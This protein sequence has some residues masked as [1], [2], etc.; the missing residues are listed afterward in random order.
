MSF[1]H[2]AGI[3]VECGHTIQAVLSDY[4]Y[5][6]SVMTHDEAGFVE[7]NPFWIQIKATDR[8]DTEPATGR[9]RF[10]LDKRDIGLW[11]SNPLPVYLVVFEARTKRACWLH[12]QRYFEREG[13]AAN[14]MTNDSRRVFLDPAAVV[15]P[16][17]VQSWREDKNRQLARMWEISHD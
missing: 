16:P 9:I 11:A 7:N 17:A 13:I 12:L 2:L 3:V 14:A 6:A 10:T 8:F 15:D 5:D 4:G 1:H